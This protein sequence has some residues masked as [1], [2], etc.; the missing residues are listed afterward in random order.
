[1]S[2]ATVHEILERIQGLSPEDR[3]L[4]DELLAQQEEAEWSEEAAKARQMAREKGINQEAIDRTIY[5]M[6]HGE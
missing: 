6:R 3:L 5:A 2:R 1:M 4:L